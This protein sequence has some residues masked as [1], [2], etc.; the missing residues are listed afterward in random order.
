VGGDLALFQALGHLLLAEEER[1]PGTVVDRSFVE[2]QTD[3]FNAYRDARRELDWEATEKATGLDRA[4]KEFI[5]R[6]SCWAKLWR[7]PPSSC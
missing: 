2:A 3:G 7:A 4:W 1:N 6:R 5:P